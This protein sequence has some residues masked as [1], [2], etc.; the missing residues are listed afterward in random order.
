MEIIAEIGSNWKRNTERESYVSILEHFRVAKI[1]GAT[2]VKLQLFSA[3]SLYSRDR[4]FTQW[5]ITKEFEVDLNWL[6]ELSNLAKELDLAFWV[7][8]FDKNVADAAVNY[9][10]CLKI[11]SG[12]LTNCDLV[13]YVSDL[14]NR[15]NVTFALSTGAAT[16][17]EVDSALYLLPESLIKS[18][19]FVLFQCVSQYLAKSVDYNIS[20]LRT[21]P[22]IL[23]ISDHTLNVDD[24]F[25]GVCCGFGVKVFEKHFKLEDHNTPDNLVSVDPFQFKSYCKTI[26]KAEKILGNGLKAPIDNELD[27]R[28]WARRGK[29]GLRPANDE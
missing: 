18:D 17:E 29:D 1:C 27:E 14:A 20:C 26:R 15:N 9:V 6:S 4:A 19:Q 2:G 13:S 23:G 28:V 22:G 12:D 21:Y 5:K 7:S 8:V 24:L 10:D 25:L 16:K 11:A 3:D